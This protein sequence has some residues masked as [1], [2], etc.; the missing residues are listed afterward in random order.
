M[1]YWLKIKAII[2]L[3][4]TFIS[5]ASAQKGA[6]DN[7]KESQQLKLEKLKAIEGF[8]FIEKSAAMERSDR[9]NISDSA[10]PVRDPFNPPVNDNGDFREQ[11]QN[12]RTRTSFLPNNQAI[13]I[14]TITLRGIVHPNSNGDGLIA[15][16]EVGN[17]GVYMVR[18]GDEI[19][20]D[21]SSPS[22]AI[23]IK[24]ISRLS[25]LVEAGSLGNTLII[26]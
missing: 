24:Q 23:K 1:K 17:H 26:R 21:Q 3:C 7:I 12:R 15:L 2:F 14:P 6:L 4:L 18:E 13:K 11:S 25:V 22:A 19:S 8:E 16:L 5:Y 9:R 20:Y 10:V